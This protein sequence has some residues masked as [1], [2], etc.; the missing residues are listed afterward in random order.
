MTGRARRLL[1]GAWRSVRGA[2]NR[3]W[4]REVDGLPL[5]AVRI[6]H[7]AAALFV[8]IETAPLLK[9]YY[10]DAG[11]F[12]IVGARR[13]GPEYVTRFFM[14][15]VLGSLEAVVVLFTLFLIC[16]V[17]LAVGYRTRLAA[18]GAWLLL[19]W[20]Q[21]RNPTFLNGGD[22]VLRLTGLY[23]ALA[24]TA[25]PAR[26]R[27]LSLDRR[28]A[29]DGRG[30]ARVPA[31]TIRTVQVQV[32]LLYFVSGFWKLQ[33]ET[34]W[35]GRA[36]VYALDNVTFTRFGLP[37]WEGLQPVLAVAGVAVLLWELLFP[38]L[39][40]GERTRRGALLFGAAFHLG[41]FVAM[42]IGVFAL[43]VLATYPAFLRADEL[44]AA[45]RRLAGALPEGLAVR[46]R[47]EGAG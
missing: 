46:L 26:D 32:A 33:G 28:R 5:G 36:M 44:R 15:D 45:G 25:L 8:W 2:W 34:W 19:V 3:F 10:S 31:W 12:P 37:G 43:A 6:A 22:E 39:V 41:I 42:N 14:L 30:L 9:R 16:L 18:W 17:A 23:L 24:Y 11:E 38:L 47:P 1:W 20:F 4:F 7:A 13:W 35:D 21:Y 27:A 29:G 40:A